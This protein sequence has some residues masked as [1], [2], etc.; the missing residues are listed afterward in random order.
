MK[1]EAVEAKNI[2]EQI[3]YTAEKAI[4]KLLS[5]LKN[6]HADIGEYHKPNRKFMRKVKPQRVP[7]FKI[8]NHILYIKIPSWL[9]W[10]GNIDKKLNSFCKKNINKYENPYRE[11]WN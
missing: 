2:A 5:F 10:L 9:V 8:E 6:G 7:S 1:K 4:K 11:L 3:I